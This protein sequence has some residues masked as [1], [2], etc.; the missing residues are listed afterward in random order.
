MKKCNNCEKIK[1]LKNF[2]R[3]PTTIDRLQIICKECDKNRWKTK[4][5]LVCK[6]YISQKINSKNR[7][8]SVP[9]Y[10]KEE[11]LEWCLN[12]KVY[13]KLYNQWKV[14]KYLKE[15]TPSID[16]KD[17]YK[18]YSFDNIRVCTWGENHLK[19]AN[20]RKT[21]TNNKVNT[22]VDQISKET[23]KVIKTFS[24]IR[25]AAR[26]LNLNNANISKCC[27][28]KLKTCGGY[29]WKYNNKN[30]RSEKN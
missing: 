17:D 7:N 1:P 16:R 9:K 11:F 15:L 19:A 13:I 12:N 10:T 28:G 21:G 24:S 2:S 25:I 8:H 27:K 14:N 5:G 6:I 3:H 29:I 26:E 22:K 23:K 30:E 4:E 18:G 20:S